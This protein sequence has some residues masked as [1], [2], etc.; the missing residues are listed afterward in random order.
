MNETVHA[1]LTLDRRVN[2]PIAAVWEAYADPAERARWSVPAGEAL[3]YDEADFRE[4]GRDRYRCGPPETLEF[5]VAVEYLRIVPQKL[6]CYSETVRTAEQPLATSLLTWVFD[7]A[8]D[9]SL[10]SITCQLV[11]FVGQGMVDGNRNGHAKA[12]AQLSEFLAG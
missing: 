11:S 6:I 5:H 4:Q 10:V 7:P 9:E 8:G 2:A 12:L 3:V 1:T